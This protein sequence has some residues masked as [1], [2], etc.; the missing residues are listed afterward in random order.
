MKE[1][2]LHRFAGPFNEIP[3]QNYIQSPVGLVP[4][5]GNQTRLIFHLFYTFKNGNKS[6]NEWIPKELCLVKYRDLDHAVRNCIHFMQSPAFK[7]TM[8]LTMAS[9]VAKTLFFGSTDLKSAFRQMPLKR[10]MWPIL[11]IKATNLITGKM[12]YF[13]DK[14]LPFGASISCTL[15]QRLS[16]SLKHIVETMESMYNSVTNYLD[17]FLFVHLVR[18]VCNRIM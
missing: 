10:K 7:N 14:C 12:Q 15:F 6:V 4:K 17:D 5:A 8:G 13:V 9:P 3:F 2:K 16:N 11:I 1:V 18:A